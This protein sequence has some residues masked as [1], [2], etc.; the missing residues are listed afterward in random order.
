MGNVDKIKKGDQANNGSVKD[1][2]K[3]IKMQMAKSS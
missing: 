3:I 1:P 2:D